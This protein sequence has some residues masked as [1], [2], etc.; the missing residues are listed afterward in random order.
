VLKYT[1]HHI[2]ETKECKINM[3]SEHFIEAVNYASVDAPPG[4]SKWG[5]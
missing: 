4:L 1:P 2:L 5:F 3:I